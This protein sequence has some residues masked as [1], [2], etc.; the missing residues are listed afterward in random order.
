[1]F[2]RLSTL[3]CSALLLVFHRHDFGCHVLL[4]IVA[5]EHDAEI[6]ALIIP[7]L[8]NAYLL[9]GMSRLSMHLF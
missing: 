8:S 4:L 9:F 7:T 3:P 1:M 5:G 6:K 2:V